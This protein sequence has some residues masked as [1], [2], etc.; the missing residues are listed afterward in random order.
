MAVG[1]KVGNIT[2]EIGTPD[3]LHAFFCTVSHNLE[4]G[5]DSR[6]PA[7][8]NHLYQG[9]L[10]VDFAEKA[11]FELRQIRE[12]LAAFPPSK[13]VWDIANLSKQP[14][15]GADISPEITLLANYFVTSTGRDLI[16]TLIEA[17]DEAAAH[18]KPASIVQC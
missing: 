12:E 4:E 9:K 15:W 16:S 10:E 1:I 2:D 7:L 18:S 17:L 8:L 3:F 6:F 5:W 14:P 13:V 11:V